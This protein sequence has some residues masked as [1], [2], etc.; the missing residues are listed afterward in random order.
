MTAAVGPR[1]ALVL[2]GRVGRLLDPGSQQ[3]PLYRLTLEPAGRSVR[4]HAAPALAAR[5]LVG[6]ERVS[7]GAAGRPTRR[8]TPRSICGDRSRCSCAACWSCCST[9]PCSGCSG[10]W[11]SSIAGVAPAPAAVAQPGP[12][13]PH[14]ARGDAGR[15]LPPARH[16]LRGLELRPPGRGGRAEPRPADHPD[17]ARRGAHRGRP[18][19][20]RQAGARRA[21]ARA[22]PPNRRRSRA[23]SSADGS[24]APARRCSRISGSCRS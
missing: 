14:P 11:P 6:A 2:P 19:A 17:A 18:R 23:L 3:S 9:P 7:A 5:G 16:R 4:G 8:C 15:L 13:L 20:E 22:E 24:P 1:S 10:S 21:A 12:L